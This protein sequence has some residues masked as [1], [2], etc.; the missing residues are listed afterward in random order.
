MTGVYYGDYLK[1][2]TLLSAQAPESSRLGKPAHDEMLFIIVH[3]AYELWFKQVLHEMDAIEARFGQVP[4]AHAELGRIVAGFERIQR[5]FELI[6]RQIDV[7][8]T[9][10][11]LDFLDFRDLLR[12]ASGFQ[13]AQFRLI[14]TRLGL[15]SAR[16][17]EF[18]GK[19]FEERLEGG[20]RALIEAAQA[21][22]TIRA[23]LEQ[24]LARTPFLA[25]G[26]YAFMREY[27]DAVSSM[28]A[29]DI[30]DLSGVKGLTDAQRQGEKSALAAALA[31]FADLF[32][33]TGGADWRMSAKAVQAALFI[34]VYRDEPALQ[35]PCRLIELLMNIDE[36]MTMWR[37][38]HAVMVERMI[39]VKL[40]TGG[41]AG[42]GYLR[43]TAEKHRVFLDL[44]R[45]ST[46]LIPRSAVPPLPAAVKE[47]LGLVY[48]R[49][50]ID[51]RRLNPG[52]RPGARGCVRWRGR[53]QCRVLSARLRRG[54]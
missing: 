50:R 3:Q 32:E 53:G 29:R 35:M 21:R 11:P 48:S 30:G 43:A 20:D 22:P 18:G 39:G 40:G 9:M 45:L 24:W 5:I 37:Y 4:L 1:L 23:R 41:S 33:P 31:A 16:R 27:R 6:V 7:L 28:L 42:H 51:G 2:G 52:E 38:R 19:S 15:E 46:Y 10:T 25:V 44:F 26:D 13:S 17:V 14:E 8:E 36:A 54:W 47:R 34:I 12:P 49:R